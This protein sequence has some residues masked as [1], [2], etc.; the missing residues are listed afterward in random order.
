MSG[1]HGGARRKRFD[2]CVLTVVTTM[3]SAIL[4]NH[5]WILR[6]HW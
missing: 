4:L 6:I 1:S 5:W 2:A 3:L